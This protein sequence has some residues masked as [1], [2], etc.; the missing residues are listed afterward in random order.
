MDLTKFKTV[1]ETIRVTMIV[2]ISC[3]VIMALAFTVAFIFQYRKIDE[4]YTKALVLDTSGKVYE[5]TPIAAS[6]MRK[7]EYEDHIKTFVSKWYSFD[8]STYDNNIKSALNLIGNRGKELLSE[9]NDINMHNSLIQKKYHI[10]CYNQ[11]Y[12]CRYENCPGVGRN[13]VHSNR[14]S[15]KRGGVP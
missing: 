14:L 9:Y 12:T 8:E 6:D 5:T 4:A 13:I 10:Q 1:D 11:G 15:R 3:C 2:A 7:Y